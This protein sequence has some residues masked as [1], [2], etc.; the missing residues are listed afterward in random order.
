[1]ESSQYMGA[2]ATSG[3]PLP[4]GL[5]GT[6]RRLSRAGAALALAALLGAAEPARARNECGPPEA[7]RD[8][9][10]SPST[11]DP[12]GGNIF[13]SHDEN[14]EDETSGGFTVRLTGDLSIDYDRERPGDDVWAFPPNPEVRG[15]GA[16]W[17]SPGE[18]G[19]YVGDISL[20]S[21][22]DVTSNGHGIFAGHYGRSGALRMDI[23]GGNIVTSGAIA[24]TGETAHAILGF[25]DTGSAGELDISV[26]GVTID[27]A[28]DSA[29]G[30]SGDHRGEGDI[31]LR[32][33]AGSITIAG[34]GTV[35]VA[36][37]H[38]G[39]GDVDLAARDLTINAAGVDAGGVFAAH[40]GTGDVNLDI[41]N[42]SATTAGDSADGIYSLHLGT[43]ELVVSA[44]GFDITTSGD[45]ADGIF[46]W[47]QGEGAFALTA[48]S[49]DIATSGGSARGIYGAHDGDGTLAL[50]A[51][52]LSI[53][54][55][56]VEGHGVAG[57]H[58]GEGELTLTAQDLDIDTAGASAYGVYAL[59]HGE[60]GL[61][62]TVRDLSIDT[63]EVEAYGVAGAHR[64][65]GQLNIDAQGL[66]IDTA[67]ESAYGILARHAGAGDLKLDVRGAAIA[68]TGENAGGIVGEHQDEGDLSIA[69]QGVSIATAGDGARGI[70][71]GHS[72][73]AGDATVRVHDS[74][75]STA[76]AK[77]H[78]V[79]AVHTGAGVLQVDLRDTTIAATGAGADGVVSDHGGS[80][81]AHIMVEGGSVRAAGVG[82]SGVRMG[83]LAEDRTASFAALVG[84]D[85]YR[86]QSVSVNTPATGGSGEGA[87]GVF[88]A[89]GGK[90]AIGPRG[91]AGAASGVAIQASGGTPKL[92]VEIDLDGRRAGDVVDGAIRNDG[93]ET[94]VA[95]NGV[96][97]HEGA[98]GATGAAAPNGA[99][100]LT[101]AA[102]E[103]IAGR[104]FMP[105][106][107]VETYAPR[108]AVYEALPGLLLRLGDGRPSG[109]RIAQPGSPV[110]ARI[111][112]ARG[113][114]EPGRAS[115]GAEYDFRRFS[116][117]AG[118]DL[119][120]GGNVTG[121][122]FL[123]HE[124]AAA[125]V[126]SPYGGGEI[127]AEGVGVAADLAW[128]GP[129]GYYA[130]GRLAST[131]LEVDVSSRERGS[132]AR[133]VGVKGYDLGIE[134]GRRIAVGETVTLTPR[135]W[136]ARR[137]LSGGAFTDSVG[138]RVS[139][140]EATRS[141]GGI[142]LSAE[143][144]RTIEDETLAL[145]ASADIERALGAAE[146]AA[147]VSGERLGSEASA[148]RVLL[149][150]GGIWRTG[151]FSL[152]A[153]LAARGSGS[154][155]SEF[156]GRIS[157]GWAF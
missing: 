78:G 26:R 62:L 124:S 109:R 60:G 46:G 116:A 66:A 13:Y 152:G 80:G 150:L 48:R 20:Y 135:A 143:T 106:H 91:R 82:A 100:D 31:N 28:G 18:F 33:I 127:E 81:S 102:S 59:H 4:P 95:V 137:W 38:R 112:A 103:T 139:L 15:H 104:T 142:G 70:S 79:H 27:T 146:T 51:R 89:G 52:N 72:F 50:T 123:R 39:T 5:P 117:E 22:A 147:V 148:T 119:S 47:H 54:T 141:T 44:Q 57:L 75:V 99:W 134:A 133:D 19:D 145:R 8:V 126:A 17:I 11:Y 87:A 65:N 6:V 90:V 16:V 41:R 140:D 77:A 35:G 129:D 128:S 12:A 36:G 76:G 32:A 25:R 64:G 74:A 155:D 93:G 2:G 101:L 156:S 107:F 34:N 9:V 131:N 83:H 49:L 63:A 1:M 113:S 105:E 56:G 71:G 108:A 10:C 110:R 3:C 138:S 132:L 111:S 98:G 58:D 30:I 154:D 43:G 55:T 125:D 88:L 37:V 53:D 136:T 120:L 45:T 151:R 144:A 73:M 61:A 114:Y 7:G 29:S 122:L 84:E 40:T 94:T 153:Q 69:A 97:L 118:V 85:G 130:R 149:A 24:T 157:L 42:G 23:S 67:G 68:T 21:S 121:S 14:G 92:L 86:R 115:A 96:T